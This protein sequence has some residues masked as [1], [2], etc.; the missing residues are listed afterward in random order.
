MSKHT[1][2]TPYAAAEIATR[3][4]GR[5]VS[6]QT[7][8]GLARPGKGENAK[9]RIA[10]VE[11]SKPR[12][13]GGD[14]ILFDGDAFAEWLG[15]MKRGGSGTR[16]RQDFDALA[17]EFDEDYVPAEPSEDENDDDLEQELQDSVAGAE[18]E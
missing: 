14:G 10:T 5:K 17:K 11:G 9:S 4:L 12:S 3:V 13:E 8:Y 6:S 7:M 18:A 15:A 2:L 1:D 16:V